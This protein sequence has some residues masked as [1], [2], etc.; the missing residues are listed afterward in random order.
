MA[1]DEIELAR[2][3]T[4]AAL[5]ASGVMVLVA[6]AQGRVWRAN[7]ASREVLG[8]E[9]APRGELYLWEVAQSRQDAEKMRAQHGQLADGREA[10]SGEC[11]WRTTRG[12]AVVAWTSTRVEDPNTG[13]PHIVCVGRDV[14]VQRRDQEALRD[15]EEKFR[16]L[17]ERASDWVWEI[18]ENGVY[19]YV[20]PRVRDLLGYDPEEVVGKTPFDFMAPQ[21]AARVRSLFEPIMRQRQ[22]FT[23]LGNTLSHRDG[24]PVNVETN[25]VPIFD[26]EGAFRGYRG[27]DRDITERCRA[28]ERLRDSE[29][30]YR[31]I[32][33]AANDAIFV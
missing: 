6:D 12:G 23:L 20:S 13:L 30:S 10:V 5:E 24:H 22:P 31:A 15:S 8:L 27:T 28:E 21:E 29:A 1:T 16:T 17:V 11:R 32:F 33:N 25:G 14:T 4:A 7:E 18:D 26:A 9:A 19:T 2:C 3:L